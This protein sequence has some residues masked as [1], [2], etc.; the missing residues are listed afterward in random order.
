MADKKIKKKVIK[1]GR[2][3]KK[4]FMKNYKKLGYDSIV[5]KNIGRCPDFIMIKKSKEVQVKLETVSSNFLAHKHPIDKVDEIVCIVNDK[6]L[7]KPVIVAE[8]LEFRGNSNIK[9]TLSINA[10]VYNDFQKY[11]NENAF[12]LSKKIEIFIKDFLKNKKKTYLIFFFSLFFILSLV[13][14]QIERGDYWNKYDQ[15]KGSYNLEVYSGTVNYDSKTGYDPISIEIT[16]SSYLDY[17]YEMNTNSTNY[18]VYFQDNIQA[19]KGIRFEK[20]GY[21]LTYDLSGGRIRWAV[22]NK[23]GTPD[24]G[25]AKS[26]GAIL[27][28]P[29]NIE[30][31]YSVRY[32][33]SFL[34]TDILYQLGNEILKENF[35]LSAI[36]AGGGDFVYLEYSGEIQH[37]AN[38]TIYANGENQTEKNF[39][40]TG[41]I[42]FKDK[43]NKTIFYL[44]KPQVIDSDNN[45]SEMIYDIKVGGGKIQFGLRVLNKFLENASYPVYID[46]SI[47]LNTSNGGGDVYVDKSTP[48][49]NHGDKDYLKIQ[50][51]TWQRTYLMF[52]LSA[53]P[54]NQVIDNASLCLFLDNDQ[55]SQN[56]SVNHVYSSS[57]CE[58]DG[59]IDGSPS[60]E[61]TWNNQPCGI[62]TEFLNETYCNT[63]AED[64]LSND[65]D[66]DDTWQ[67]WNVRSIIDTEYGAN[68]KSVSIILWTT[69]TGNAD[70]F[71][72]KEYSNSNL[73]PYLNITYHL[74][75]MIY[76]SFSDFQESPTNNS[77]YSLG[78][79]YEFNVTLNESNLDEIGIEF[80]GTN[81]TNLNNV[82][83]TYLFNISNLA[84]GTYSY[85]WWA[86]DTV[87]NYNTSQIIYYTISKA[88]PSALITNNTALTR[89]YDGS[90]TTIAISE[91]N[92]G[93]ADISYVLWKNN[94]N[95]GVSDLE[96][97]AGTYI[98]KVNTTGGQNYSSV[99]SLDAI[100]L[101]ISQAN[102]AVN[103]LLNNNPNN[104]TLTYT[105]SLNATASTSGGT[106]NL[107]RNNTLINS[108]NGDSVVL[109]AEY[110]QYKANV[111]GNQNYTNS[112]GIIFYANITKKDPSMN[113]GIT[114]GST[115]NYSTQTSTT[116]TETNTGDSDLIYNLFRNNTLISNP[117]IETLNSGIYIYTYNTTGG[118]NYSGGTINTT[119]TVNKLKNPITLL[120]NNNASN[121]TIQ[122]NQQINVSAASPSTTISLY[123]N[124]TNINSENGINTY[125]NPGFYEY[126]ANSSGN[127]NYL[128][129]TTG[130]SFFINVTAPPDTE[131]PNITI[132]SPKEGSFTNSKEVYLNYTLLELN[133]DTCELWLDLNNSW[134]LNQSDTS[135]V[136]GKNFFLINL[137]ES[138]NKWSLVCNDSAN[139][140]TSTNSTFTIDTI[141]P[142]L[143]IIEPSGT[144]TSTSITANWVVSDA[145]LNTCWYEVYRGA[146]PDINKTK[147]NCTLYSTSFIVSSIG[148]FLFNFY[149]NDS[150]GNLNS[151]SKYFNVTNPLS[152]GG[153]EGGGGGGGGGIII[154]KQDDNA[155]IEVSKLESILAKKGERKTISL[156]VKN[157][158]GIFLNNCKLKTSGT[159]SSWIY[160]TKIQGIAPGQNLDF[161]FDLNVPE[162]LEY[163]DYFGNLTV[164]C[165]EINKSQTVVITVLEPFASVSITDIVQTGSLV[166]LKYAFNGSALKEKTIKVNLW[167][168]DDEDYEV[169]RT[170]DIFDINGGGLI[171][172][173]VNMDLEDLI[174]IYYVYLALDSDPED[175][176]KESIILGEQSATGYAVY[177]SNKGKFWIYIVF[178]LFIGIGIFFI[179]KR[180][181]KTEHPENKWL[182]R[183][184]KKSTKKGKKM[185]K[186]IDK[187]NKKKNKKPNKV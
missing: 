14:A 18:I 170:E 165:D 25:K 57:W 89:I 8:E 90:A 175:Y 60:C 41:D 54:N 183:N 150:A 92:V 67:C 63:S 61:M 135:V 125:L 116:A 119:L 6:G 102:P 124:N 126:F 168:S 143:T 118:Q 160:S 139:R 50:R 11:C 74:L 173:S 26:I 180:H 159:I 43:N 130:I 123:R 17:E 7:K 9:A 171:Q 93:D 5:R 31:N 86:K 75:D 22:E 13:S 49:R 113:I 174:G 120:I 62:E 127:I 40:T 32:N 77:N 3:F 84:A 104:L 112:N 70:I 117:N 121:L 48:D 29:V 12:I 141:N 69:D 107:F 138:L 42:K 45:S 71:H 65:G 82:S 68:N 52:N 154:K 39:N 157:I 181:G 137:S 145:N 176:I 83:N 21:Y 97:G 178:V 73:W 167:V 38:L 169:Y 131:N 79:F 101:N 88:T 158:G 44:P 98:Y 94:L 56:I 151:N 51:L 166:E 182:I 96:G 1:N 184:S 144:K 136:N 148:N 129:N 177:D 179:V 2:E 146:S 15:G 34:N 87:G 105:Q 91:S 122:Y 99:S 24:Y 80:N 58:G 133:P 64:I 81:Y 147:V 172:R 10:K 111:T 37:S 149:V 19:G 134:I 35:I 156:N 55:G 72:T 85:Y 53:V 30:S 109:S 142:N 185:L 28:A 46:P 163:K 47:K 152:G 27:S 155:S 16:N 162:E 76:P 128:E 164:K 153:D 33:N 106:L 78:Q 114:P 108:E 36:P 115:V 187:I 140:T 66:Q 23:S 4:W 132:D 161:V 20:E 103:L 186:K 59:G 100:T 110:Y 95:Q